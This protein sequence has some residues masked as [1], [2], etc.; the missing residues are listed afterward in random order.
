M[1]IDKAFFLLWMR[2]VGEYGG[3]ERVVFLLPEGQE[4]QEQ[5]EAKPS[6]RG[7]LLES[8]GDGPAYILLRGHQVHRLEEI[9]RFLQGESRQGRQD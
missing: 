4:V 3:R 9:S 7:W 2:R 1:E 5:R 8:H 6:N